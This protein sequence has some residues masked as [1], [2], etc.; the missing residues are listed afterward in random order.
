MSR[1]SIGVRLT[2]WYVA[3]FAVAQ[4]VFGT[5]MWISL[6]HHL[7]SIV[8][9]SLRNEV[10]DL[11]NFLTTQKPD[12]SVEKLQEETTEEYGSEHAGEYLELFDDQHNLIFRSVKLPDLNSSQPWPPADTHIAYVNRKIART[13]MRFA[14][15]TLPVGNR[16]FTARIGAPTNEV[17]ETLHAFRRYLE[18]LVPLLLAVAAGVGYWLSR[19][20]LAPVDRLTNAARSISGQSLSSRLEQLHTGDELQRL[21]DTLNQM[22]ERIELSFR[23]ITEFTADASHELR[24]PVSLIRTEAELALRRSRNAEEYRAALEHIL[25]EAER[26]TRLLEQLLALART[27]A[28]RETLEIRQTELKGVLDQAAASWAGVARSRG[29]TFTTQVAEPAVWVRGDESALRRVIDILLDNAVKY[30]R[31]GGNVCLSLRSDAGRAIIGVED[32]GIGIPAE[33]Q[34]KIFERFYRV[35][36]A[37]SGQTGGAGLGLAIAQWIVQ[38]HGGAIQV[39]STDGRGCRFEV[40]LPLSEEA[41][42]G[43]VADRVETPVIP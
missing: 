23:R 16:T 29:L 8:D 42:A 38:Q 31:S 39:S 2:L 1:L 7:Y 5:V 12:A 19:R 30:S 9:D 18:M 3:I 41:P 43:G 13:P 24:T 17:R 37:R 36:K 20:A 28:G 4:V 10:E 32:D 27:D 6:R 21:A 33:E 35:D 15:V 40:S 11:R 22:L 34:S 25:S 14:V 26:T